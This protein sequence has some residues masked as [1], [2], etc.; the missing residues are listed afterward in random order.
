MRQIILGTAGHID[1][2]KTSFVKALTGIDTDRLKEEKERG[3]TIELGFAYLQLGPEM[4]VGIVDVPGH[5]RFVRH[6]VAGAT[7]IDLV[8]LIIA[9]D[10]GVMP[11]TKEHLEIC[12]LLG[13][14]AGIVV[15]TKIDMV[16]RDWLELVKEDV[17]SFLK[18]TFLE[19]APL[20]EVSSVT[21]EGIQDFLRALE[22]VIRTLPEREL[23][24]I[25]RMPIDRVF[26][27]KGFGTVVTGTTISGKVGVGD[28]VT[29]YPQALNAKIRSIQVHGKDVKE[30]SPGTRTALNLQGLDKTSIERGSVVA[31]KDSLYPTL[32]LDCYLE[33]L[34]SS[35][36]LLKNR[37]EIRFHTGTSEILAKVILLDRAKL[38]PGEQAFVH[39]RLQEPVAVLRGDRF[40]MRSYS[41]MRT[42]G[43]GKILDPLPPKKR[44]LKHIRLE[45]MEILAGE[46]PLKIVEVCIKNSEYLGIEKK[47]VLFRANLTPDIIEGAL[48]TLIQQK[49]IMAVDPI[50]GPFIHSGYYLKVKENTLNLIKEYHQSFPLKPGIQKE[51]LKS[52]S[53]VSKNNAIFETVLKDLVE[54]KAILQEKDILKLSSFQIK[55]NEEQAKLR[56]MILDEYKK[57]GIAPPTIR[58]LKEKFKDSDIDEI[59]ELLQRDGEIVKVKDDLL[60]FKDA[61]Q[62]IQLKVFDY[63]KTNETIN[64]GKFKELTG[65]SRKYAIPLLE[66]FDRIQLT[67][68]VGD[69]RILRRRQ[70]EF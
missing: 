58:E 6:M 27:I 54:S 25:F 69:E 39:I 17:R 11:Q 65:L 30:T 67:V 61:I 23:G 59:L 21:G 40:V 2:G 5:E 43:G 26:T 19:Q 50:K 55:L 33:L 47:E 70:E 3:I 46:D 52:R 49:L 10:E 51:E 12:Q 31:S 48:S 18:G 7:G 8:A 32:G 44:K 24:H 62:E 13:I 68:R 1:H 38:E 37:S 64:A 53:L 45:D 4:L 28:E 60:F 57:A 16:E 9:A 14:K 56:D 29:V 22:Q 34:T 41:P 20:V 63:L 35:P 36:F 42:I 15:I 66:Y